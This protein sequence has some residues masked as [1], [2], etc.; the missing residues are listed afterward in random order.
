LDG[1]DG[2]DSVGL[3]L[4]TI[5][6]APLIRAEDEVQLA[7]RIEIGVY[8]ERILN[9]ELTPKERR[10]RKHQPSDLE[11]GELVADGRAAKAAFLNA[12]LRL[13]VSVAR[14]YNHGQLPL[15]DLIQ[16]GNLGL[17][18]AVEK[19]DYT[20]GFKFSTYA[21]W[22]VRQAITRGLAQSG[23]IVR[24]PAH[25][26]E[27]LQQ[28]LTTRRVLEQRLNRATEPAEIAAELKWSKEEVMDLLRYGQ[29]HLSLD[30]TLEEDGNFSLIDTLVLDKPGSTNGEVSNILDREYVDQLLKGLD[31]RSA[32]IMRRRFGVND[33]GESKLTEIAKVWGI[34]SER[35]RQLERAAVKKL[36]VLED[37][38]ELP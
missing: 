14:K 36:R 7:K 18:R 32:D 8:A 6:S 16:E 12:N 31:E 15:L 20:K 22:W 10:V 4:T 1:I 23:R 29:D 27:Q 13:V 35:I 21:T 33:E 5:A 9:D 17:I 28:V 25:V 30:A 19:F 34:S 26:A 3:Y 37:E 11:L 2:K 38:P 24:L